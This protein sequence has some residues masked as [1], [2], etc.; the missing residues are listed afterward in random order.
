MEGFLLINKP[1]GMTSHDVVNRVRRYTGERRVGHAGTLDPF[2]TGLLIVGVGRP[3]TKEMQN[4]VGLDKTYEATFILGF[5]SETDDPEGALTPVP[6]PSQPSDEQIQKMLAQFVGNIEQIPPTYSAIKIG[7]KKMYEEARKG[8]PLKAA[9]RSVTIHS[10]NLLNPPIHEDIPPSITVHVD[11]HCSSGTYIRS[12][13]RDLGKRLQT[14]G[15]VS[16]LN[17]SSIGPF[18]LSEAVELSELEQEAQKHLTPVQ[19]LLGRL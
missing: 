3:A 5:S 16:Q 18:K 14:G 8:N 19:T 15:Y 6:W 1:A 13:A 12:I 11:I 4:L 2:A 9:P 17:R 7:G 10:I